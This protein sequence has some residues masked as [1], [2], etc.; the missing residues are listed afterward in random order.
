VVVIFRQPPSGLLA[1]RRFE[2]EV[3]PRVADHG[4]CIGDAS[5]SAAETPCASAASRRVV[6]WSSALCAIADALS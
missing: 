1:V 5:K 2:P 4:L 6:P 3:A